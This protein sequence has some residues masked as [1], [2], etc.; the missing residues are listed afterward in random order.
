MS[1]FIGVPQDPEARKRKLIKLYMA[2]AKDLL[3]KGEIEAYNLTQE[4]IKE[5]ENE[6]NNSNQNQ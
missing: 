4:K 5:L 3:D 6:I 2:E 1:P